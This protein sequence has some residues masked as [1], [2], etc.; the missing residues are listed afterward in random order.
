[1]I[2]GQVADIA[3]AASRV[4]SFF[5]G[6]AA[7]TET[8]I[9]VKKVAE[10][11]LSTVTKIVEL[12]DLV[13][14]RVAREKISL[15]LILSVFQFVREESDTIGDLVGGLAGSATQLFLSIFDAEIG[16]KTISLEWIAG[17][18]ME[19]GQ[20]ALQSAFSIANLFQ[21]KDCALADDTVE[22]TIEESGDERILGPWAQHGE[23]SEKPRYR[24]IRDR[25]NVM[26]EW[27]WS[28]RNWGI[29]VMDRSFGRGW[30]WGWLGFG[31]RE[32]YFNE[33]N[34]A[35]FPPSN[36]IKWEGADPLP[37]LVGAKDGGE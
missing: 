18:I 25:E 11:A 35:T 12:A 24:L 36:W 2:L 9:A 33:Q 34:T 4:V 7:I 28:R 3:I 10:F 1:M 20:T 13:F 26:M 17:S 30:W 6:T 21:V 23:V 27:S 29:W 8:I 19:F 31:W 5:I 22:F 15:T 14:R 32:L 37:A 16:W